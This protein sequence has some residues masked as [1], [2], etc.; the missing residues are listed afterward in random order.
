MNASLFVMPFLLFE[1][2]ISP[3]FKLKMAVEL[4]MGAVDIRAI[5]FVTDGLSD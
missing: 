5:C 2:C 4:K 1:P 3:H